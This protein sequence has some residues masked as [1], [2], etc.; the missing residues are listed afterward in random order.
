MCKDYEPMKKITS[1]VLTISIAAYNV[2][3]SIRNTIDSLVNIPDDYLD[4][5]EILVVDDGSKDDTSKIVSDYKKYNSVKLISKKNGGYGSTI[6]VSL[7]EAHGKYF[8]QLD[9]GDQFCTE[10]ICAFISYLEDCD[11]DLVLSPYLRHY[12]QSEIDELVDRNKH[13]FK[14]KIDINSL[15]NLDELHMHEITIKTDIAKTNG[16]HITEKCF[17]TD[18]EFAFY[19]LM[20]SNTISKFDKPIYRYYIGEEGQSVSVLGRKK[21]WKDSGKMSRKLIQ[22]Y[23]NN[24]FNGAK[25]ESLLDTLITSVCFHIEN[26][27]LIN[28]AEGKKEATDT[29]DFIKSNCKKLESSIIK[30][31]GNKKIKIFILFGR[32]SYKFLLKCIRM[33]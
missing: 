20:F 12:F 7:S 2:Q 1:K 23:T 17:Y 8:K 13:I 25:D 33:K 9:A 18:T 15:K 27:L 3:D 10:N 30:K 19:S 28:S 4:K 6:N 32:K 26:C 21:H 11:S 5:I 22:D 31:R 24:I 29:I 16:I 14:T